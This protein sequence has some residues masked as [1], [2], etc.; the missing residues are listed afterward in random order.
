MSEKQRNWTQSLRT[1]EHV[2]ITNDV[3]RSISIMYGQS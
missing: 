2:S 3:I 1:I